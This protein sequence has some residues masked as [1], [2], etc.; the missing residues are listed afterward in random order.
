[1]DPT[2]NLLRILSSW[3]RIELGVFEAG[4]SLGGLWDQGHLMTI[5]FDPQGIQKLISQLQSDP[6]FA[7]QARRLERGDFR[8]G[9]GIQTEGDLLDSLTS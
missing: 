6:F 9:G 5:P 8:D 4:I 1:M 2:T 3:S 7:V